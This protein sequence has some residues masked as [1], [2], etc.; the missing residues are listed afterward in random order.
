MSK[1]LI[2]DAYLLTMDKE[3]AQN[4]NT[5]DILI[6]DNYIKNIG[7]FDYD[8]SDVEIIDAKD[9]VALPGLINCHT[10]AAMSLLRGYADDMELMPW[11][12]KK[13]WPREA[14]LKNEHIYWG[15]MLASLEMIKTGTTTFADMYMFM[16][17]VAKAVVDSG[18]RASLSRGITG[19]NGKGE[20]SLEESCT[21]IKNWRNTDRISCM[22]GPHAPYTCTDDYLEKVINCAKD[23]NVGIHIHLSEAYSEFSDMQKKYGKTPVAHMNDLGMFNVPTLAAHCVHLT[24]DDIDLLKEK[25]VKV[26]HN[27]ESNM[28]LASGMAP[29]P[30]L[31]KKGVVVGL[32]TDGAASNNNLN[33]VEEMHMAALLHKVSWGNPTVVPAYEA[34]RMGTQMGAQALG[35]EKEIGTLEVGKKADIILL[36]LN[37]PHLCPNH[38]IV[39]N[40]IYSAQGSDVKTSIING[41][42]IMKNRE[43]LFFDEE[44][45]MYEAKRMANDLLKD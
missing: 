26:A 45:V 40:I 25:N 16:D 9:C 12:E 17:E 2:K 38:D 37:Q 7:K 29:V 13:I 39:A 10:H 28:K 23:L 5:G 32:G 3:V 4:I 22:L 21:F 11:L 41:K 24:D 30:D 18:I 14:K 1:I 15:S 31:L 6:E 8:Q 36:D 44:K 35:L 34:L 42:V 20:D 27:P 33:M 19:G 43:V